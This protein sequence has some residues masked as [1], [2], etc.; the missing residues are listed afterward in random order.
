MAASHRNNK[1]LPALSM[2][3]DAERRSAFDEHAD[4][5]ADGEGAIRDRRMGKR[6]LASL[7]QA[8]GPAPSDDEVER[9][10]ERVDTNAN[11]EIDFAQFCALARVNSDLEQV[12]RA[13][14]PE[15][16]LAAFFRAGTTLE[17][18]GTMSR[19]EFSAVVDQAHGPLVQL[20]VDL[21]AQM[22]A[23]ATAQHAAQGKSKFDGE[24]KGGL[25]E[26]FYSGVTGICGPPSADIEKGMEEEHRQR[27]DSHVKFSTPN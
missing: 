12:L 9:V 19:A 15:R 1:L 6:G 7:M 26:E 5:G 14:R 4:L 13:Q 2:M 17:D 10:L 20:L 23:V 11:G 27:P 24:L 21:G 18:L 8:H 16:V 25:L 22:A 3:D